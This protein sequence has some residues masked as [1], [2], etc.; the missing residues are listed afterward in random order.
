MRRVETPIA[1]VRRILEAALAAARA[2]GVPETRI[3]LDPGIGFFRGAGVPWHAW[4]AAI[5]GGLPTLRELGRPLCVGVSRK[6]F[7][8]AITGRADPA[9]RLPGSLAATAAAVLGGAALVRAH[10]VA[11]TVDAV[12]VAERVREAAR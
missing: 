4:D 9:D 2:A 1:T 5:L 7:I 8:G 12:R 10:D 11:E 6:S 3:V